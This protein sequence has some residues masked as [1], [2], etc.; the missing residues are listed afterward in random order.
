MNKLTEIRRRLGYSQAKLAEF[1]SCKQSKISKFERNIMNISLSDA[2]KI[3]ML[4]ELKGFEFDIFDL[5]KDKAQ[6]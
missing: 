2:K 1:L 4:A 3:K 5:I 6:V